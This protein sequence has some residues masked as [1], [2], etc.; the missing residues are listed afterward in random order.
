AWCGSG[1]PSSRVRRATRR[2]ASGATATKRSTAPYATCSTRSSRTSTVTPAMN[3][4]RIAEALREAT[5]TAEVLIGEGALDSIAGV[6]ARSFGTRAAVVVA[7]ENTFAVAG[8][9]VSRQL[10]ATGRELIAPFVFAGRP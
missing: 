2:T 6:F 4:R 8:A 9:T 10:E 5:D 3:E 1:G 7:D